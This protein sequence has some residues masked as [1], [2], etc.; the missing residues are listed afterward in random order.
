[1][2][3]GIIDLGTL[4]IRFDI[5]QLQPKLAPKLVRAYRDMLRLGESIYA[6]G[7]I[8][9]AAA[10]RSCEQFRNIAKIA[11][12]F[13]TEQILAV[14]TSALRDAEGGQALLE[15][16]RAET[17]IVV[18]IISGGEEAR[19]TAVGILANEQRLP[20]RLALVDIGG[21]STE[22]SL[23]RK[24]QI[25]LQESLKIGAERLLQFASAKCGEFSHPVPEAVAQLIRNECR[26]VLHTH[27]PDAAAFGVQ[28][29]VGSSGSIRALARLKRAH[30]E[31][32]S[33]LDRDTVS[34]L[35]TEMLQAGPAEM[36]NIP[37][38]EPNRM[39]VMV[40]GALLFEEIL[41]HIHCRDVRV[42]RFSLRHGIL[43]EFVRSSQKSPQE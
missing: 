18:Q 28:L 35:V 40:P 26:R 7:R 39:M 23:V 14:A 43:A 41:S 5:Y 21:G 3:I 30:G 37:G 27:L 20:E 10:D 32:A 38:M 8:D 6:C 42:T 17:G 29:V 12:D 33:T 1:M 11:K 4:S 2:R 24:G 36:L 22:I 16:I 9:Q 31:E 15:R 13:D 25:E 19:L 34:A